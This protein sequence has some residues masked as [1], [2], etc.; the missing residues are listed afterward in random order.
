MVPVTVV[1]NVITRN[2]NTVVLVPFN[3]LIILNTNHL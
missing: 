2:H 1:N 3:D